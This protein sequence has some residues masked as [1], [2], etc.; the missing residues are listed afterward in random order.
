MQSNIVLNSIE[1]ER[2][3]KGKRRGRIEEKEDK[4]EARRRRRRGEER[5]LFT[6]RRRR[7][8]QS[9][10]AEFRATCR[11]TTTDCSEQDTE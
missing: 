9:V 1:P 4:E 6:L 11:T 2:D 7:D 3:Q 10:N 5:R 8:P